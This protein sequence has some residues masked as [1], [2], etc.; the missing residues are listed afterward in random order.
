MLSEIGNLSVLISIFLSIF[1]ILLSINEL[2]SV[3]QI[4]L[5]IKNISIMQ[6]LFTNLSFI[7]L[8]LGYLMSDFSL[9]NVYENSHTTKPLLYKISG[10]WGN[11][12]GSLLLWINVLVL[13]SYLFFYKK[14]WC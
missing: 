13:F 7:I 5:K 4:S 9:I 10:V 3:N 14:L 1:L 8:M 6:L 11:H 2:K 12:E